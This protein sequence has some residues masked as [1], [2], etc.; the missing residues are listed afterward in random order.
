MQNRDVTSKS[1]PMCV[2]YVQNQNKAWQEHGRTEVL[3]NSLNPQFATKIKI[4][5]RFEEQQKLLFKIYDID[6]RNPVLDTHD[7]LGEAETS[8][9]QIVSSGD[10]SASLNNPKGNK[11]SKAG[12][13]QLCVRAEEIGSSKEEVELLFFAQDFK[14]SGMFSKPD[15]FL[16]I[17]KDG[18]NLVHRTNFI[19]DD[20]NPRWPKFTLPMR[21][22]RAKDGQEAKLSL[23]VWNYNSDGSHKLMGEV[24]V[25]TGDLL[26]A[27]KS[28]ALLE[29]SDKDKVNV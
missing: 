16:A 19:K 7:F 26:A 5:Y 13:Q 6:S 2:V 27:P 29:K 23:Q 4:G 17:Y 18:N 10:F 12:Q 24:Q 21:A 14:K 20:L 25:N 11:A 1:D 15:P 3:Q 28:F 9:G 22:L 8:L